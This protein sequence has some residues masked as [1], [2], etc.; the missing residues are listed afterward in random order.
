MDKDLFDDLII[1]CQE[2]IEY[3]RGQKQLKTSI[4]EILDVEMEKSQ[5]LFQ[6][7][8]KLS[9]SCKDKVIQYIDEL[10][11]SSAT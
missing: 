3:Q 9:D 1:S 6:K 7:I 8:E 5:L 10:V 11:Q 4:I 2:V